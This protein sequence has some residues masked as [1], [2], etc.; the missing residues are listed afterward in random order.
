MQIRARARSEARGTALLSSM[1]AGALGVV[2]ALAQMP[3]GANYRLEQYAFT[4]GR[5]NSVTPPASSAYK[6]EACSVGGIADGGVVGAG[7]RLN[8]GYLV[9]WMSLLG[10]TPDILALW[11]EDGRLRLRWFAVTNPAGYRVEAASN[12]HRGFT[13][14]T[15][16]VYSGETWSCPVPGAA[17]RF[18]RIVVTNGP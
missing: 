14:D 13:P 11:L 4:G 16:G 1:M 2:A 6:L 3:S 10:G 18:Y 5:G 12:L 9:P 17:A 8:P 7:H 15:S